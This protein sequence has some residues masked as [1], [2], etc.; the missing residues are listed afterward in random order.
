M[1][2]GAAALRGVAAAIIEAAGSSPEEAETVAGRL[3]AA[4]LTGH[5]SHGVIR[6]PQYVDA[7]RQGVLVPNR[8]AEVVFESEVAA[9]LDGGSGY[10]QVLGA[11]AVE[12]AIARAGRHGVG[13][14]ALRNSGHLGRIGDWAG[15][16]ADAGMVSL[17]FVNVVGVPLRGVPHGGR[18]ARGTTNP[19]A[20]GMPVEGAP[21]LVLDFATTAVAEGKVR[22]ARN[23]GV[24]LPEGCLIDAEGRPTND[25]A[26][27][28]ADPPASLLPFGGPVTGH[29]G[30]GLWLLCDL[31]AGALGGGGCSRAPEPGARATSNMLS[32]V[33]APRA[34]GEPA[35]FAAEVERYIGF[36]R[37]SR[38][39]EPGGEVLL[40]GEPERRHEAERR[41]GGIPIDA[42]SWEQVLACGE[43]VGLGRD[44]LEAMAATTA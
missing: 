22:V 27:M 24:P 11:Q 21:P 9:V 36:V 15:L 5:D 16:A 19:I 23:K 12:A 1:R 7:V 35:G 6:V 40:P 44:R 31:L 38:P 37:S 42:A 34:F 2:I 26:A 39:R 13:L 17:H 28:Y 4:N 20:I 25:P 14:A 30:G 33:V 10:G 8:R 41:A 3:V 29:K 18:D 43:R 32:I